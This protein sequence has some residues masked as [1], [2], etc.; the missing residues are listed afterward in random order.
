MSRVGKKPIAIAE[1]VK[2][3][4]HDQVVTVSGSKGSLSETLPKD[5]TI[6]VNGAIRRNSVGR[7]R[8]RTE[9]ILQEQTMRK[10]IKTKRL[11]LLEL[12]GKLG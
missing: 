8:R 2:V 7:K 4:V 1:S 3:E 11:V 5:V 12:K 9:T 10:T 6:A